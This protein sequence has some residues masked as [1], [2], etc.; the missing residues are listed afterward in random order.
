MNQDSQPSNG[1]DEIK[2]N[3]ASPQDQNKENDQVPAVAQEA[4]PSLDGFASIRLWIPVQKVDDY[5]QE[6]DK[7]VKFLN[8]DIKESDK[9]VKPEQEDHTNIDLPDN[10]FVVSAPG[11]VMIKDHL[12]FLLNGSCD[13]EVMPVSRLKKRLFCV[14]RV[15]VAKDKLSQNPKT[16]ISITKADQ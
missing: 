12:Y 11:S 10:M 13:S 6:V 3:Y 9:S 16:E 2:K 1:L 8:K 4:S 5:F 7:I 14:S 15:P